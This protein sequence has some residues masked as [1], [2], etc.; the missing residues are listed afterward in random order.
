LSDLPVLDPRPLNDLFNLGGS[1]ELIQELIALF[2]EDVPPR[3]AAL[4]AA[5]EASD[6]SQILMEAHQLKWALSNMG[7][8][9]FADLASR[10]EV[11]AREGHLESSSGS[12][13]ELDA[14]Y[15]EA[16]RALTEAYPNL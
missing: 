5:F 15:D 6:A 14:A 8:V 2:R 10:I 13:G 16:L 3:L 11:L 7:L 9:R 4:R 12:V 1:A